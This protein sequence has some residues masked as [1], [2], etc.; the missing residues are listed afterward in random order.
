MGKACTYPEGKAGLRRMT[1]GE[2]RCGSKAGCSARGLWPV[3]ANAVG[4]V[5]SGGRGAQL[6]GEE[7]LAGEVVEEGTLKLTYRKFAEF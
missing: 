2:E 7:R 1:E 6:K 5:S 3:N 4:R